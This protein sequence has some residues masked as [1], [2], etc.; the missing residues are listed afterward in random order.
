MP[1]CCSADKRRDAAPLP[2]LERYVS[3]RIRVVSDLATSLGEDFRILSGLYGLLAGSDPIPYYDHLL[4]ASEVEDHAARVADQLRELD[5]VRVVLHLRPPSVDPLT[6]PYRETMARA[7][8]RAGIAF[9]IRDY[10]AAPA[11]GES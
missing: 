10:P 4:T 1:T 6:E 5:S 7:C 11:T 3:D 8:A 9:E 2:A